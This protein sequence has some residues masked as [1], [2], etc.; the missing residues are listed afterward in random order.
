MNVQ[1]VYD[2]GSTVNG[3]F[4]V[5]LRDAVVRAYKAYEWYV[6]DQVIDM[7]DVRII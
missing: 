7:N 1:F 6:N 2:K 4:D 3:P 5:I